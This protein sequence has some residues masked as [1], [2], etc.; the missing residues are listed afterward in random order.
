MII[1]TSFHI[2]V[3]LKDESLIRIDAKKNNHNARQEGNADL[4]K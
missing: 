2:W 1:T 4:L 3:G